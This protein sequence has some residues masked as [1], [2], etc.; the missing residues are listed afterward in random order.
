M[1]AKWQQEHINEREKPCMDPTMR[2]NA[3]KYEEKKEVSPYRSEFNMDTGARSID[4]ESTLTT[5]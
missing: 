4:C 5:L 2:H 3:A 1:N